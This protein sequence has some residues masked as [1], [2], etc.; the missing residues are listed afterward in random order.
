[1]RSRDINHAKWLLDI[2]DGKIESVNIC[3]EW[4]STDI[5]SDIYGE[6]INPNDDV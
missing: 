1:M 4:H 5:L 3:R 2:S 6:V